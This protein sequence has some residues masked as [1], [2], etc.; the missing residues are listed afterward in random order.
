M[1]AIEIIVLAA[2]IGIVAFTIIFNIVRRKKGKNC[3]GCDG[4]SNC[5]NCC[6]K[7]DIKD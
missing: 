6:R 1:K 7:N 4:C 5:V 3:C 2:A